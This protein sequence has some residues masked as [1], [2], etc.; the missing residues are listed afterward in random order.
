MALLLYFQH[1][2]YASVCFSVTRT[3]V[4]E[5]RLLI[6]GRSTST[7]LLWFHTLFMMGATHSPIITWL[8][9][10]E[11]E[12]ELELEGRPAL[13]GPAPLGLFH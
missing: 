8:P 10:L 11:L 4:Q 3:N 12:L 1:M 7:S 9:G 6:T 5:Q 13:P 2:V